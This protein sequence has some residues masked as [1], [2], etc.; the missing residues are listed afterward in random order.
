MIPFP[1]PDVQPQFIS[2]N[3][4]LL[5]NWFNLRSSLP[6]L[7][8]YK[9]MFRLWRLMGYRFRIRVVGK[10]TSLSSSAAAQLQNFEA[11]LK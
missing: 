2:Q 7:I 6:I 9:G 8:F 1:L 10:N 11:M 4:A 5:I 3:C